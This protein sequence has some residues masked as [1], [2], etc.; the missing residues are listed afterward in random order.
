M[1]DWLRND[2]FYGSQNNS[3]KDEQIRCFACQL[4]IL[5]ISEDNPGLKN[6]YV[7]VLSSE[8]DIVIWYIV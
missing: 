3:F 6:I 7:S 4:I 2:V 1:N 5:P 8:I